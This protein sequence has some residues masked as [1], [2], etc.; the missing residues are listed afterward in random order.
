M[1]GNWKLKRQDDADSENEDLS[2]R[3][4][5]LADLYNIRGYLLEA[6]R[7]LAVSTAKYHV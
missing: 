2:A 7:S 3:M 6:Y 1:N 4:R 5:D